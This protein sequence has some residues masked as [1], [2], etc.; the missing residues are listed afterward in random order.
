M[1][2]LLLWFES[3][4][5]GQKLAWVMVC[6]GLS[7][8]LEGSLPLVQ[9]GYRKWRHAAGNFVFLATTLAIN[10][11]F[12]VLSLG[13]AAWTA[14]HGFGLL[15]LFELPTL[16]E[17]VIAVVVLDLTAQ[18]GAHWLLHQVKWLWRFH[19]V[20]HSDTKVDATTGT[21][22]H[23]GDYAVREIIA[24][25]ALF[26]TGAPLAFY[27][28]YRLLTVFFTFLTHANVSP[29]AWLDATLSWVFV[30]PNMH[31][32]H[33]HFERPWTDTNYGGILSVWDRLF[34]T[35]VYGD[36]RQVVYGVDVA[37][38]ARDEDVAHQLALP[39]RGRLDRDALRADDSTHASART[40]RA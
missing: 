5:T 15:H 40:D 13:A 19:V 11:A 6:I 25:A 14:A 16:A 23:P 37:D 2:A 4:S 30:T 39:F 34:G 9:L 3:M 28:V 18:Y 33:H 26:V 27:V 12:G 36:P 7:W 22:L 8:V 20:H 17:L 35:F 1:D 29:P 10:A 38:P 31:K 32:F 21:R 24:L